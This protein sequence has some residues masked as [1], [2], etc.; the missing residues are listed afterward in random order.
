MK[1]LK[2]RGHVYSGNTSIK[3]RFRPAAELQKILQQFYRNIASKRATIL[4]ED[5][6]WAKLQLAPSSVRTLSFLLRKVDL[7]FFLIYPIL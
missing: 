5:T 4:T 6:L 1:N 2:N 3:K 7:S